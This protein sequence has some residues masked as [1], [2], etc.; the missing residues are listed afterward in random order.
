MVYK[1]P[2]GVAEFIEISTS[3]NGHQPDSAHGYPSDKHQLLK[4]DS[5]P[6]LR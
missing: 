4:P 1:V 2:K 5:W 6:P 3:E